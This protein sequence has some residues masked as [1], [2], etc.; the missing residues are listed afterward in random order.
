MSLVT[1]IKKKK[2]LDLL[3]MNKHTFVVM[4]NIPITYP[5]LGATSK[6]TQHHGFATRGAVPLSSF[7]FECIIQDNIYNT[8]KVILRQQLT[9]W[10]I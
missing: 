8:Q 1:T 6:P 4:H 10:R 2:K 7:F 5:F 9:A 3:V